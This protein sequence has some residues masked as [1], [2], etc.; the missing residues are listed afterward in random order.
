MAVQATIDVV[1]S[2]ISAPSANSAEGAGA[3]CRVCARERRTCCQ[4]HD[5]YV[6]LGDCR[7]IQAFTRQADFYEYR[8]CADPAYAD[9]D[10]DPIWRQH[11]FRPDGSRRVIKQK[12]NGDCFFLS[13]AGCCLTLHARPLICRLFPHD[14]TAVGISECWDNTCPLT[15]QLPGERLETG[16]AGARRGEAEVWHQLLYSEIQWEGKVNENRVDL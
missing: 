15:G 4:D 5:I 2:D 1:P 6:T 10:A 3:I 7:R 9:Q 11:V 12:P 8:V 14:Y 13:T 16:I